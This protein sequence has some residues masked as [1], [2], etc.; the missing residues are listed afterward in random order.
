MT[1]DRDALEWLLPDV[2]ENSAR[3]ARDV[4]RFLRLLTDDAL[5]ARACTV[6]IDI[7]RARRELEHADRVDLECAL[8]D[9]LRHHLAA[10]AGEDSFAWC[11]EPALE[12][13]AAW[14][15]LHEFETE[16]EWIAGVPTPGESSRDVVERLLASLER[17]DPDSPR[18]GLWRA[19]TVQVFDGPRAAE[20]LFRE[21][22]RRVRPSGVV[23]A[24]SALAGA[25]ECLLE[26]GAPREA[27]ALL[28]DA[29]P[30]HGTDPRLRVLL[31]WSRLVT[32]DA[33]GA[34][35]ALVGARPWAG[36]IPANLVELRALRR[37]WL[38]CLA[39]RAGAPRAARN[40]PAVRDRHDLGAA[41]F[42][43]FAFRP[44]AG[45]RAVHLDVAVGLRERAGEWLRRRDDAH[46]IPGAPEHALVRG[47]AV[48]FEHAT[49]DVP[50]RHVAG[51][52]TTRAVGLAPIRDDDGEVAGWLHVECEHHLL[53]GRARFEALA[54][55]WRSR[56]LV[57]RER[58]E[59][60]GATARVEG[61]DVAPDS[62]VARVFATFVA[63]LGV[64]M[65][66]RRHA[67][68][69]LVDGRPALV[70]SGG[71]GAGFTSDERGAGRALAR[72]V[73][74]GG[75][76]AFDEPDAA[77]PWFAAAA[78]GIVVPIA[79]EGRPAGWFALE[80]SRRRDFRP[81][82]VD[83]L[84]R[85]ADAF[86]LALRAAQF[87]DWHERRFGFRPWFDVSR[88]DF[89]VFASHLARAARAR[90][91]IVLSG[92]HGTGKL[93]LARWIHFESGRA[94]RPFVVH[95]CGLEGESPGDVD[96]WFESAR[97][98]TL[99]LDDVD[100]LDAA[101]QEELLRRLE[102]D[103]EA[104][105]VTI[106]PVGLTAA[107]DAGRL[108]HDLATRLERLAFLVPPLC[109][110]REEIPGLF[111]ALTERFARE[112]DRAV[113]VLT[114]EALALVWRQ[115]WPDNLRGLENLAYKLVLLCSD[116]PRAP[117]E[118]V[119]ADT[120]ARL[121]R[122]FGLEFAERM[123]SR[124]PERRDVLAA[125]R[126]TCAANGRWNKTRASLYLGWDPD[127]L[128]LRMQ[129]EGVGETDAGED[130]AWRSDAAAARAEAEDA[131]DVAG[132]TAQAKGVD[133]ATGAGAPTGSDAG[134]GTRD[135]VAEALPTLELEGAAGVRSAST[136]DVDVRASTP[137]P[138]AD[139][140]PGLHT[141]R[142]AARARSARAQSGS[143]RPAA[144]T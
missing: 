124:R 67:C 64:K 78:S 112:E 71:E 42:A 103:G 75:V 19:R 52:G 121:G 137:P 107:R 63:E 77:L 55:A 142:A 2:D 114:D 86:G 18:T 60:A 126:T 122:R 43:V 96:R 66:V 101:R 91:P 49:S 65:Q 83:A 132:R 8:T 5:P 72:S 23:H 62:A 7:D 140:A 44:D 32:G 131:L 127:T 110:R 40:E 143:R 120:L 24:R 115:R 113:P 6:G 118:P 3:R 102:R 26:R 88:A 93:V 27:R 105:L 94:D 48:V 74:T 50:L 76:V 81:R 45:A 95:A 61:W 28:V 51:S 97:G 37:D 89:R 11:G 129:S 38:P 99:V 35:A 98:G 123:P 59:D 111:L 133:A 82:D 54:R 14:R 39:G 1:R 29:L 80:S 46:R 119:T 68:F 70:L 17:L 125:L 30:R 22:R 58:G 31:A 10:A 34:R 135:R 130:E 87:S 138:V 33:T 79:F 128:V 117:A 144:D 73:A 90:T 116:D 13:R 20:P 134:S 25:A 92:A 56:V 84:A 47:A 9:L 141:R 136:E 53:P 15:V 109:E 12:P 104:R 21:E 100:R 4:T 85:A 16:H 106:T 57:A 41:L 36:P 139:P 108:R 69:A